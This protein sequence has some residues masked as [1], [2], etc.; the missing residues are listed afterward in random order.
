MRRFTAAWFIVAKIKRN[1]TESSKENN[2]SCN[3]ILCSSENA[4]V[5]EKEIIEN[6]YNKHDV[7]QVQVTEDIR[8]CDHFIKPKGNK[9]TV[10]A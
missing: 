2:N 6:E 7:E 9:N 3:G 1:V 4:W 5:T 8:Q 10:F